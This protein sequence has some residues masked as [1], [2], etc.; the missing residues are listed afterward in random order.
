MKKFFYNWRFYSFG[1]EQY[2]Q[3]MNNTFF[4]N[5]QNLKQGNLIV[6]IYAFLYSVIPLVAEEL[7]FFRVGV[8]LLVAAIAMLIYFISNYVMQ[9]INVKNHV[10]Y[11]LITFYY[12]NLMFFG[13]YQSIWANPDKPA[14]V[15]YAFLVIALLL[16]INPP[17]FNLFLTLFASA[18]FVCFAIFKK[19][20]H[21]WIYDI[22]HIVIAASISM[23]FSW[24]ISK[25]RMGLE[26]SANQLEEERNKYEDQ[27][28]TDELTRLRNKRDFSSTFQRYLSN[29]RSSDDFI[30]IA[31]A[32]ID[33]FK[34]YND[35]YGHLKG[36]DCLRTIGAVLNNL[37]EDLGI[38]T[39]RVGGEEFA[40]LWFEK[41]SSHVDVV[42]NHWLAAIK[43]KKIPHEKSKVN[44]FVSMSIGVYISRCG[45]YRDT[46][47][48]Y[49]L[50]DKALYTAKQGGR[51][52]A[53]I[54]GDDIKEY[55]IS[56]KDD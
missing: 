11:L 41:D 8:C 31:I 2:Q 54:N 4:N 49:D 56:V 33:F 46:K 43:E 29:F 23:F 36:D 47:V 10:I 9:Q 28:I 16:F 37:K 52:A 5:L 17:Q 18:V 45:A 40:A 25:L 24:Q 55:K 26:L 27:S 42:I 20:Y 53:I 6:A 34:F 15:I 1:R 48:L 35:H 19:E 22:V 44:D 30:C 50:A 32:D 38:Y 3:C 21:I 14:S 39:A 12:F 7:H 13:I 51:N